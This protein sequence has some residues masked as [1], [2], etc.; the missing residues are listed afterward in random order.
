MIF[1]VYLIV[2]VSLLAFIDTW[3]EIELFF[4]FQVIP[5]HLPPGD[6]SMERTVHMDGT[7]DQIEAA[8]KLVNEIINSEVFKGV[9]MCLHLWMHL[10]TVLCCAMVVVF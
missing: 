1:L 5:L 2:L 10:F 6:T 7:K 4:L 3:F 8:K 9:S